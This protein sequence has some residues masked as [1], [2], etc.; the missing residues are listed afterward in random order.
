[1]A[2][3]IIL[4][5]RLG[6]REAQWADIELQA[7]QLTRALTSL[8]VDRLAQDENP[9]VDSFKELWGRT[10][11]ADSSSLMAEFAGNARSGPEYQL[12]II[13][14]DES[15]KVN[16]NLAPLEI[17]IAVLREYGAGLPSPDIAKAIIDWRDQDDIGP[18]ERDLYQNF[19]PPYA[20]SDADLKSIDELLFIQ[21]V[22][23]NLFFG[24]D[25][26]HNGILD[27]NEDDGEAYWPP[28]NMDGLLQ[29]GLADA[30]TVYGD[31]SVNINTAPPPVLRALVRIALDDD[32]AADVCADA[33]L[34]KRQGPD[35]IDGTDDDT[36]FESQE[37]IAAIFA[38]IIGEDSPAQALRFASPFSVT[39]NAFRFF[40]AVRFPEKHY[41][42]NAEIV[43]IREGGQ[44]NMIEY[45]DAL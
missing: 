14:V 38:A 10:Y 30:F 17:L 19:N 39:T 13:P 6:V 29:P 43:M 7:R 9:D 41:S 31:G 40:T 44:I 22:D 2:H 27:P 20:P 12:E 37:A 36:P 5:A 11:A 4:R 34:A 32:P 42:M 28:D 16:I 45:H 24:E 18:A 33:I 23:P 25:A 35:K 21:G 3:G 8:A 26:N 15:G 1:M